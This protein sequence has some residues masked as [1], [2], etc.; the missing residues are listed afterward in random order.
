MGS[1]DHRLKTLEEARSRKQPPRLSA[2][3]HSIVHAEARHLEPVRA[4]F[5]GQ[6]LARLPNETTEAFRARAVLGAQQV[7][8]PGQ[9]AR[10]LMIPPEPDADALERYRLAMA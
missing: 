5:Y 7:A 10:L 9:I 6:A 8:P 1:L 4:E 2:I 3:V